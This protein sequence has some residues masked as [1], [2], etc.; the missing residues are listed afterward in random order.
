MI[1]PIETYYNG[2]RFRSRLEARWAVFFDALD[3]KYK[4][5]PEGFDLGD[6][7]YYL[8]DF[9]LDDFELFIEIK[10]FDRSMV[11]YVGD[12]NEWERKCARFRDS[13]GKAILLCYGDPSEANYHRFF[14]WDFTESS[15]GTSEYRALFIDFGEVKLLLNDDRPDREI[16]ISDKYRE[17]ENVIS[18]IKLLLNN[19]RYFSWYV[20]GEAHDEQW[21]QGMKVTDDTRIANAQLTARQARFEHGEKPIT[22]RRI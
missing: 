9:Y 10:P 17:N 20:W 7:E 4:Y 21:Q 5:E 11:R 8:P 6:G 18:S 14:G 12:N 22:T 15:G 1:K 2:Y 19:S 13:T 3:M 16:F